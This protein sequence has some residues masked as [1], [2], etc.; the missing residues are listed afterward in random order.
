MSKPLEVLLVEDDE[1]DVLLT[2]EALKD[3]KVIVSMA[4]AQDGEEAL[5]RLR[6]LPPFEAAPVPDLILLDLN[7]PRVSGREVLKELKADPVLKKIPVVVLTTSAADTD[8]LRCYD[9]GANCYIT[10]PVDF[11]QFQRIIKVI[12]EFWLTIVKLP[13]IEAQSRKPAK[14]NTSPR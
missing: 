13:R 1:D 6:R 5:K 14:N 12:D 7:L 8:V 2:R 11:E 10:K 3:S 4:V 9:L